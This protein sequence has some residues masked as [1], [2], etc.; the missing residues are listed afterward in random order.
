MKNYLLL[1]IS[2]L[3]VSV[4]KSAQAQIT[5][6][7]TYGVGHGQTIKQTSDKGFILIGNAYGS[8]G[9]GYAIT[10]VAK[11]DSLGVV[12]WSESLFSGQNN[13]LLGFGVEQTNDGG[14]IISGHH[15]PSTGT[16]KL[17]LIKL[18]AAGTV[19]WGKYI[20]SSE[21]G[22]GIHQTNDGGYILCG[23][24]SLI[25]TNSA[26]VKQW[27]KSYSVASFKQLIPTSDG[28]FA[29]IGFTT[30][31]SNDI[32]LL[33]IDS[34]GVLTWAKTF[35]GS[36]SDI[37]NSLQQTN[38]GGYIIAGIT[39]SYG[40]GAVDVYLIKTAADGTLQ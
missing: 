8:A 28:G 30:N 14:Y 1:L 24:T 20:V 32:C 35:G 6:R 37:G 2:L 39:Q 23:S 18:N 34:G 17:T 4:N 25:K 7:K 19:Q 5:F 21:Y 29:M 12:N 40:A 27:S 16:P 22:Y 9:T 10:C 26:G 15:E 38:D 3:I 11:I 31:N 36:S 33:K 13:Q